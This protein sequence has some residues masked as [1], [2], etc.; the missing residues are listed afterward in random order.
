PRRPLITPGRPVVSW[1]LIAVNVLIFA[2]V[3]INS[4][5]FLRG[6]LVADR[7]LA[8]GEWWRILTH[9]FLHG[10]IIHLAC[11]MYFLYSIG[12]LIESMW[13]SARLL[14]LYLVAAVTGGC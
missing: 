6:T 4:P 3:E 11:N 9:A 8:H 5:A 7:V 1:A 2:L 10:G 14:L 12:P 13:G